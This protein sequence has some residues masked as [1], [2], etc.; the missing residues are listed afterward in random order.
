MDQSIPRHV[1]LAIRLTLLLN[2]ILPI[3]P[4]SRQLSWFDLLYVHRVLLILVIAEVGACAEKRTCLPD[5]HVYLGALAVEWRRKRRCV[6]FLIQPI[7]QLCPPPSRLHCNSLPAWFL[8]Q[9]L[10]DHDQLAWEEKQYKAKVW[11][12][13]RAI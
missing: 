3:R 9:E 13:P 4:S 11:P 8:N 5:T 2:L 6:A 7:P 12:A 1:R 10:Y